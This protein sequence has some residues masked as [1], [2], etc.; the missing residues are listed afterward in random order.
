MELASTYYTHTTCSWGTGWGENGYVRIKRGDGHS[1]VPGVCGISKNPSVA[2]GGVL[3]RHTAY[4]FNESGLL[5]KGFRMENLCTHLGFNA[6]STNPC[7]VV[8]G[9]VDTHRALTLG[10]IGV[11]CGLI[12]IWPLSMDVRRRRRYRRIQ[13]IRREERRRNSSRQTTA[14]EDTPLISDSNRTPATRV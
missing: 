11:L 10:L 1:G 7:E 4:V 12:L 8:A 9:F 2:L 13:K 3:L 6:S 14:T 5:S